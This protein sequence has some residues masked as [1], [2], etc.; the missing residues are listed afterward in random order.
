MSNTTLATTSLKEEHTKLMHT[1][2]KLR[3]LIDA[4]MHDVFELVIT[5]D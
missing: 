4:L 1:R 3:L 2:Y 5:C